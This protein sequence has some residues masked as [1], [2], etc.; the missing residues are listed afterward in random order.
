MSYTIS[1][2]RILVF[3]AIVAIALLPAR[4]SAFPRELKALGEDGKLE[5][6]FVAVE[7]H[8][9]LFSDLVDWALFSGTFGYAVRG[10]YRWKSL[11]V[12]LHVEH[13]MWLAMEHDKDVVQGAVNVGF[14]VEYVYARGLV[15][16]SLALGPSILAFDTALDDAGETGLFL[17]VRPVGLRFDV[18]EL[19]SIGFDPITF[20]L[21]A[22]I[23]D[24]IPL[25]YAQYRTVI[26][27]EVAF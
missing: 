16:S 6:P 2:I 8:M 18:H 11:G 26:Y 14:G 7:G 23:L 15:H 9:S 22:P 19:V 1:M 25:I 17:D 5:G 3:S 13:N 4:V 20:T 27:L 24:G 10:G 21:V 12:F